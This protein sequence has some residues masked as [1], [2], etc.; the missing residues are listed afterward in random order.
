MAW[1]VWRKGGQGVQL[2]PFLG[3]GGVSTNVDGIRFSGTVGSGGLLARWTSDAG[4]LVELGWVE[5][6]STAD[7]PGVWTDWALGNGLYAKVQYRF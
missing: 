4:W 1:T 3:A 7:N 5:Q 6:F 2:V